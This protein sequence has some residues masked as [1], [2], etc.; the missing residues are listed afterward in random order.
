[1][2]N[3]KSVIQVILY[4]WGYTNSGEVDENIPQWS[5]TVGQLHMLYYT[6]WVKFIPWGFYEIFYN[7]WQ[8]LSEIFHACC[9]YA[10]N[11]QLYSITSNSDKVIPY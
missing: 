1:M 10:R 5:V 2:G 7:G 3:E 11:Y 4:L 9:I 6:G 8:F